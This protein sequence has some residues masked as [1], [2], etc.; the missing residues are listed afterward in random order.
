[1]AWSIALESMDLG[2]PVLAWLLKFLQPEYNFLNHL[3]SIQLN[4]HTNI[5]GCFYGVITQF[6]LRLHCIFICA[7]FKSHSDA[8]N[9]VTADQLWLVPS[10]V[11]CFGHDIHEYPKILQNFWLG[12][13][14]CETVHLKRGVEYHLPKKSFFFFLNMNKKALNLLCSIWINKKNETN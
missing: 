6:K 1:M 12:L 2:L 13:V 7:A 14:F 10:C 3:I 5:F 8:M 9:N 4:L 11:N